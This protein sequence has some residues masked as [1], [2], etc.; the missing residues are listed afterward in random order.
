MRKP[1]RL[2]KWVQQEDID[3]YAAVL[4]IREYDPNNSEFELG[5][6]TASHD[7]MRAK[8][9]DEVQKNAAS[10][11]AADAAEASEREFHNK[12]LGV[13]NQIKA[14]FGVNSDEYASLGLKKK[15][16]YRSRTRSTANK[17]SNPI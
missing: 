5:E 6:V 16:E 14:Q 10:A 12:M 1:N 7:A 17:A 3:A 9:T 4:A 15:E 2:N 13:K 8:Q 11:A